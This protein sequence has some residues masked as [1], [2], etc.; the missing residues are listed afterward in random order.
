MSNARIFRCVGPQT[1]IPFWYALPWSTV[2]SLPSLVQRMASRPETA[3]VAARV[4]VTAFVYGFLLQAAPLQRTASDG[5]VASPTSVKEEVPEF[6][7]APL[8]TD[9]VS[10]PAGTLPPFV[11]A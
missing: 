8:V 1:L 11:K 4:T 10:G 2:G 9:T 6:T 3:S 5:G 7:P